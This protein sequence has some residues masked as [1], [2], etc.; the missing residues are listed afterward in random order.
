MS[1]ELIGTLEDSA[2][3]ET[4]VPK[5]GRRIRDYFQRIVR[6]Q[7]VDKGLATKTT[8]ESGSHRAT[9]EKVGLEEDFS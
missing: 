9:D 6:S 5:Q 3:P 2:A 7:D 4:L 1:V 8:P